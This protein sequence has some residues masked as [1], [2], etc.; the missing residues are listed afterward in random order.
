MASSNKSKVL[1]YG[2]SGWIG[3]KV[4]TILKNSF[5][6]IPGSARLEFPSQIIEEISK[7]QPD[8]VVNC[9]GL[10]G[11]P[12]VDW[13]ESHRLEVMK[14]NTIG[15]S[16]I[17][18]TCSELR[19]HHIYMGTGCIYEYDEEHKMP[20]S[21]DDK[22][23]GF[24]E[25]DLPNFT[26]SF[27]S[28]GKVCTENILREFDNTLI[29]RI[30]MPISDGLHPRNFITKISKYEKVVNIPNSMS[31]LHDL[32][33][34][35]LPMLQQKKT[36]IVN[37]TN[38]GY[39]SH[40]QILALYKKYIRSDFEWQNFTLK[41]QDEVIVAPRSNNFLDTTKL[42]SWFPE[43]KSIDKAIVGVFIRMRILMKE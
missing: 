10:T 13:C 25:E 26:R 30:R 15:A 23:K 33:P 1:L 43:I 42:E 20:T 7:Y 9:A 22:V 3:S 36:G 37:F 4:G 12:N 2:T 39:I 41:E 8:H 21:S 14:V 5:E 32:L 35:I 16:I 28:Y 40:N 6:V 18:S 17:A 31:V 19:I 29:L 27:Y 38:P 24:T 34:L 11:R